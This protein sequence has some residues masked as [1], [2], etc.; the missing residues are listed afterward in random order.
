MKKEGIVAVVAIAVFACFF[1]CTPAFAY[2]NLDGW[3]VVTR[4]NGTINGC[5]FFDSKAWTGEKTLTLNNDIPNGTVKW[6]RL[7]TGTWCGNPTNTGWVNVTFNGDHSSNELGP[8][9]IAGQ[10][11]TNPNVWCCGMGKSWWWYDVTDLVK[12]GYANTATNSYINGSIDGRVYGIVLVVVLEDESKPLIQYWI[13]DGS[14]GLNYQTPHNEGTTDFFAAVDIANL[15]S[16]DLMMVHLTAYDPICDSCLKFNVHELNTSMVDSSNFELNTWN[17]TDYVKESANY[18]WFSRGDDPYVSVT[19]AILVLNAAVSPDLA[20]SKIED[21]VLADHEYTLG[22]VANHEYKLNAMIKNIGTGTAINASTAALHANGDLIDTQPVPILNARESIELQFTWTPASS[23]TY[24][25]NVTVDA[26]DQ[27]NE[28]DEANNISTKSVEVLAEGVPD[29]EMRP[30]ALIFMPTYKW[31]AADNRTTFRVNVTNNGTKDANNFKVQV[32]VDSGSGFVVHETKTG[33][34]AKAKAVKVISFNPYNAGYGNTYDVKVVLDAVEEVVAES[35]EN[36]NDA[37]RTLDLIR[38]RIQDTH[39]W[40]DN[41]TYNSVEMFDVVKLVPANTT[42]W[43]AL[44][45]V[46]D[47]TPNPVPPGNTFVYGIDGLDHDESE[48][49]YWYL[50]MNGRYMSLNQWCGVI[51]LQDEET[52]HWDLQKSVYVYVESDVNSFTPASTVQSYNDL[53]PEPITH[54]FP[55]SLES[56]DGYSRTI[57]NTTIVY[58]AE[59]P[60]Y[61]DIANDIRDKLIARGVSANRI[62]I[63][64]DTGVTAGQKENNNHIL[65]GTYTANDM[66]AEIN[67][68]HEYFGMVIYNSNGKLFDDS[69]DTN[70][71]HGGVVQAL[72]NPYD[73]GPLG[74]TKSFSIE[75]PIILMASGLN[76]RDAKGAAKMLIEKTGELNR[77]WLV[78]EIIVTGLFDTGPGTYPSIMGVHK[79]NFTPKCNIEVRQIYT[80]PCTGTGGHSERVIFYDGEEEIINVSWNGYQGDYHNITVLP[81]VILSENKEYGYKIITGSYPQ[82]IHSPG[83]ENDYGTITCTEFID[84]N[85]KRYN[86]WLPAIKLV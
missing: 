58:P 60:E 50:Y 45:S 11:D 43:D 71:T 36:N 27:V 64:T 72:D 3:P 22:V 80:Y 2:Y 65:L 33:M 37:I 73:N 1:L 59:S 57:W 14:E 54:G 44:N 46:A 29:L 84:A 68:Y 47:V 13:N 48:H 63:A 30:N 4:T 62:S 53:Y 26:F 83:Y 35:N 6:A 20:V 41:T 15:T 70:Y 19:N 85:G 32:L 40:G 21:P 7:Y 79:G 86:D 55:M 78:K 67:D 10:A 42:A 81:P 31:H 5:V 77:F 39:H 66:I 12:P 69:T 17:V 28:S 61:S 8:I 34:S 16:A 56:G 38:V 51:Q 18:A 24:I 52:L 76:D 74:T 75:G 82:I 25:L 49:I 23:G 9:Y